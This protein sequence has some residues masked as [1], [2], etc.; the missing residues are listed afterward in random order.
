MQLHVR[1]APSAAAH[2]GRPAVGDEITRAEY[3]EAHAEIARLDG[4]R[5][6]IDRYDELSRQ[7]TR[8]AEEED[9]LRRL[10][11]ELAE[12]YP[13][14]VSETNDAGDAVSVYSGRLR[15]ATQA[16]TELYRAQLLLARDET[17]G[18]AL[19]AVRRRRG[20]QTT[21][22]TWRWWAVR[23]TRTTRPTQR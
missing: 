18:S 7:T 1:D 17:L 11:A 10:T 3:D 15:E 22:P 20:A 6:A 2:T 19:G 8:T 5:E 12:L 13:E 14:Y 23:T 9:E 4:V 16:A 21:R